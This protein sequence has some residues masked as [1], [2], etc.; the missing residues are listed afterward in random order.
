MLMGRRGQGQGQGQ[1]QGWEA[2]TS[3]PKP[4][5]QLA[6][7]ANSGMPTAAILHC[8]LVA[9]LSIVDAAEECGCGAGSFPAA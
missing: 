6:T 1:G 7:G 3:A 8:R 2:H 5:T 4:A 9:V